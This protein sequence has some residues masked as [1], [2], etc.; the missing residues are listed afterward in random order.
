M[1][2]SV[3]K[4]ALQDAIQQVAKVSPTRSTLPILNCI[5]F[6]AGSNALTLRSTDLEI[7][8]QTVIP[9]MVEEEGSV[10]IPSRFISDIINE[11]PE[12]TLHFTM[13]DNLQLELITEF[14]DYTI[15]G[16]DS[17][18]FPALPSLDD[19]QTVTMPN[20]VLQRLIDKTAFA[21][22]KDEL[23][24]ALTGVLFQFR[25]DHITA[26][27]TDGHRLSRCIRN[28]VVSEN[29]DGD[30]I[31]PTKFLSIV[32][33]NLTSDGETGLQV[34]ESHVKVEFDS[35]VVYTR[36]IN[37]RFP[38]YESVIPSDNE[39]V[40]VIDIDRVL[41]TLKRVN[42]FAN[43][44]THQVVLTFNP[45]KLE[46]ATEN[47]ENSSA[48]QE[49]LEI[50]YTSDQLTLGYNAS[51]VMDI[52]RHL[53]TQE[54]AIKLKSPVSAG[55]IFPTEQQPDEDLTMLLMPIRLNE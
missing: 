51:Y 46:V 16:K 22:S 42:I 3:E 36:I 5:L 41:A 33:G 2:F 52:L 43:K 20:T 39:K 35:S 17:D 1:R 38:D 49:E 13:E 24:P 4:S 18:D 26:V 6:S 10:A 15:A 30:V 8:M 9:V 53:D 47:P 32:N 54:A 19:Q 25:S 12:T 28:D 40:A 14:G 21:I 11:L 27:A 7:T 23:K 37:E 48:A 31:I 55:L 45:N 34:G 50:E 44:S 29:F